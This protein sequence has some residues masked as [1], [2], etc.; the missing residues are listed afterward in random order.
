[1]TC[2][3]FLTRLYSRYGLIVG[4][5]EARLSGLLE[6]QRVDAEYYDRNKSALLDK[7]KHAGLAVEYSDATAVV[8]GP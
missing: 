7:M 2:D 8:S 3:Q 4:P 1:M 6:R 5:D